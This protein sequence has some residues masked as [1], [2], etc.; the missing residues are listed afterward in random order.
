MILFILTAL[1]LAPLAL[2]PPNFRAPTN[3]KGPMKRPP[4]ANP[5]RQ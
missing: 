3:G 4:E 2:R 1:L 5:K